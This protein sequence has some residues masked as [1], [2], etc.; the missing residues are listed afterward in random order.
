MYYSVCWTLNLKG[1][2][3]LIVGGF[4]GILKC[5]NCLTFEIEAIL[6]GHG[7]AVNDIKMHPLNDS[8]VFSAS[9]DESIRMFNIETS[10]CVCIFAGDR[11]HRD[12]VLSLDIHPRGLSIGLQHIF[13]KLLSACA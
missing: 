9:K 3:L 5:I 4:R 7:N 6:V 13:L 2:P 8:I 12:E 11:G 10:V 1:E